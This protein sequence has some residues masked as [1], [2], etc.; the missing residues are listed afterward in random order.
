MRLIILLILGLVSYQI[1]GQ[2]IL[3]AKGKIPKEFITPSAVKFEKSIANLDKKKAKGAKAKKKRKNKKQFLLET[4]FTIDDLLQ[5]GYIL[6]NDQASN[7][8]NKVLQ[9]LPISKKV[10]RSNPRIYLLNSNV[11][12]AFATTQGIIFVSVG[13][14]ANL[15]NEAQLAY[16][17]S[18]E[19]IHVEHKHSMNQFL[20]KKEISSKNY[21]RNLRKIGMNKDM[22]SE[23]LYSQKLE[24]EADEEGLDLFLQSN[25]SSKTL[26]DVFKILHY[27]DQ[28]FDRK[29]FPKDYFNDEYYKIPTSYWKVNGDELKPIDPE[30]DDEESTHPSAAKRM[31]KMK[32]ILQ[33]ESS[34]STKKN[35]LVGEKE[36]F[37]V[38]DLMRYQLPFL[39]LEAENFGRAIFNAFLL[40]ETYP[41]DL[42][43]K[44][45]IGKALYLEAK[46]RNH[47]VLEKSNKALEDQ[48]QL[49]Y[50]LGKIEPKELTVLA[51]RYNYQLSAENKDDTELELIVDDL[52]IELSTYS[53]T[54]KNYA[55]TTPKIDSINNDN[56]VDDAKTD[57]AKDEI[58]YYYNA[59]IKQIND[60]AFKSGFRKG[61]REKDKREKDDKY[62]KS[63]KGQKELAKKEKE[64]VRKGRAMG[65]KKIAIINPFYLSLDD[66]KKDDKLQYIRSET[67]QKKFRE[68]IIDV[69]KASKLNVE[70][71]DVTNIK[72]NEVDKFNDI[73]VIEKYVGQQFS[74]GDMSLTPGI[75]QNE[76]NAIAEKYKTDYFLFTGVI[77]MRQEEYT[78]LKL[79]YGA[80]YIPT[81]PFI[82]ADV[83]NPDYDM[84][85]Y[86]VLFDTKTGRRS[87][88]KMDYFD[89][90]DTK[91]ILKSHIYDVFHQINTKRKK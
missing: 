50:F 61:K 42:E 32:E 54:L 33:Q 39:A 58:P 8:L 10:K 46:M 27:S 91:Y 84:L 86:A 51:L 9:K 67:G 65:I 43:L 6:F 12:N 26:L 71:L 85:Y 79:I 4:N 76:V 49:D 13:L 3:K 81:L 37:R 78:A 60:N 36:F 70:I 41:E 57:Q 44:K 40:L 80:L 20:K 55:T 87:I 64:R 66:R 59:F 68:L 75:S 22:F 45:V 89:M 16:I 90:Q 18:H 48:Q 77:S 14:L 38:R 31:A 82:V 7:Y 62:Y 29:V 74:Y 53:K 25:Y 34:N 30:E 11:V 56:T 73:S 63:S 83:L 2:E 72:P 35:F 23:S 69:S 47:D 21:Q 24:M 5:S 15:E 52:F 1:N 28:P 19:L 17:L 88:I